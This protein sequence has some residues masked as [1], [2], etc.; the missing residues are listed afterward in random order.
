M[1]YKSVKEGILRNKQ[2]KESGGY[3]GIPY[4]FK[5]LS[6]FIPVI[7]KG[8]SIGLLA[9]TGSGKSK[10]SRFMFLYNTYK[11]Y[12]QTGYKLKIIFLP[13]EDNKEKVYKNVIC[14]YLKDMY[15]I[16]I[17]LQELD[18]KGDRLLPD[19]VVDKLEEAEEFFAEFEEVVYIIDGI[20]SPE[21]ILELCKEF[22]LTVGHTE[23]YTV[24]I[25]GKIRD[26]MR[27]ISEYHVLVIVDNLSNI[28]SSS[29]NEQEQTAIL[30]FAK[31]IVREKLCNYFGWSVIQ[32]MQMDFQSERQQYTQGGDTV[33]A[34]LEPTLAG[35]ADAKR[36]ARSMHIILALFNPSRY[37]LLRYPIPP[38]DDPTN[39]Y[40]IG[41]LG[42]SFRSLRILKS[43]DSD[44]GRRIP[45]YFDGV[46]E[47]FEELPL[48]KTPELNSFYDK[49]RQKFN[50]PK[51]PETKN[52]FI[53]A[54]EKDDPNNEEPPF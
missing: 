38:K 40:D 13:L 9:P 47:T 20:S 3:I 54:Y 46:S 14:H 23:K 49:I 22:A 5:R 11:F 37:E 51:L 30:R 8:H 52:Q 48:P 25:N 39:C 31:D 33:V 36:V 26:Q 28:E 12:K 16:T 43:N 29:S 19:F 45:L 34:K 53:F 7:E 6:E 4:P 24:D 15:D 18:S 17:S 41:L 27:W 10:L 35:I 50:K 44:V 1:L 32:I 2:L 21:E 42:N